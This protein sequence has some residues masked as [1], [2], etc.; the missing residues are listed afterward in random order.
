MLSTMTRPLPAAPGTPPDPAS[1]AGQGVV[2][3]AEPALAIR[4]RAEQWV[5]H[6]HDA[7]LVELVGLLRAS[8]QAAIAGSDRV[9][10][11]RGLSRGRF[12][13]LAALYR[14]APGSALT[15][16]ELAEAMLITPAGMKKRLDALAEAGW[17]ERLPDPADSRKHQIRLTP[18]G[19]QL[20]TDLLETFFAAEAASLS[21]LDPADRG[22][23]R[24]LLRKLL[25]VRGES[26]GRAG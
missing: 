20:V 18:A 3:A 13:V 22:T 8:A 7:D 10:A 25:G 23:L 4:R 15:Q 14:A 12:D 19:T 2:S 21:T 6:G 11:E 24:D 17:L 1:A 26:A 16:A 9:L 5:A